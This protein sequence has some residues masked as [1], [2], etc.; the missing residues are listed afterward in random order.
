MTFVISL[1]PIC[2]ANPRAKIMFVPRRH[3]R[4]CDSF[5]CQM[6]A[7]TKKYGMYL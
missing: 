1:G 6:F 5:A 4:F 7:I 3:A 2:W